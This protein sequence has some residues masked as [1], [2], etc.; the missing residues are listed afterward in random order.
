MRSRLSDNGEGFSRN[1][2]MGR[3]RVLSREVMAA[4]VVRPEGEGEYGAP[5]L[6]LPE[7]AARISADCQIVQP[8][9]T[10]LADGRES[11]ARLERTRSATALES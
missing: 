2:Y 1:V 10:A 3:G 6:A 4:I 9:F 5:T 7:W 11:A 8:S